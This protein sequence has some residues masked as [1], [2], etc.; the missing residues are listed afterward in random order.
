MQLWYK[1]AFKMY[2]IKQKPQ[3]KREIQNPTSQEEAF[4]KRKVLRCGRELLTTWIFLG[5]RGSAPWD[6]FSFFLVLVL[7]NL[8]SE[9]KI[10]GS[11]YMFNP[12]FV[13]C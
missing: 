4:L 10:A 11:I 13:T 7:R 9:K 6:G 8:L 2:T 12:K 3:Q 5:T 1:K